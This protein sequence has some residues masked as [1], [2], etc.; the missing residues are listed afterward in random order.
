LWIA[1]GDIDTLVELT[2]RWQGMAFDPRLLRNGETALPDDQIQDRF[3]ALVQADIGPDIG[4]S[5]VDS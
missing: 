3:T 1:S 2:G 5:C 4:L